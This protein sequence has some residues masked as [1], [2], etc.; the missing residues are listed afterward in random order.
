MVLVARLTQHHLQKVHLCKARV[1]DEGINLMYKYEESVLKTFTYLIFKRSISLRV[2]PVM[3]EVCSQY[4]DVPTTVYLPDHLDRS[5]DP[6]SDH[7]I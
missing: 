3:T 7:M 4:I 2:F 1:G 6:P 5:H